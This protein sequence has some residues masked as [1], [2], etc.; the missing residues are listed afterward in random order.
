MLAHAQFLNVVESVF[1]GMARAVIQFPCKEF[2]STVLPDGPIRLQDREPKRKLPAA[3]LFLCIGCERT[4]SALQRSVRF[5]TRHSFDD[6]RIV[7]W[8]CRFLGP[9]DLQEVHIPQNPA[10]DP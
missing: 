5:V 9:F 10:I 6:L 8:S 7:P 2:A 1:S 4:T 3:T